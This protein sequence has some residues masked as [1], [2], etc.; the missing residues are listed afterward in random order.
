MNLE[1]GPVFNL[2]R[3]PHSFMFALISI[4]AIPLAFAACSKSQ[5]PKVAGPPPPVRM[6][7]REAHQ[8]MMK[9]LDI[10]SLRPGAVM[11]P[12]DSPNAANYNEAKAN[13]HPD[14][15]NPLVLNVGWKVNTPEMWWKVRRLEIVRDFNDDIY[16]RVPGDAPSVNWA[17]K[18][19]TKETEDGV[20]VVTKIV[21]GHVN[22][23]FYPPIKIDIPVTV[24]VPA[25]AKG[26]V[27]VILKLAFKPQVMSKA[28]GKVDMPGFQIPASGAGPSWKQQLLDKGWGYAIYYPTDLQPD[29]GADL[30][31][32]IIGLCNK[33]KPRSPDQWGAIRA[34][35]WGTSRVMDYLE[36]DSA[37][38]GKAVGI[39]GHSRFGK[40]AL[41]AMAYDQ[42]FAIAYISSSGMG[43][44]APYRRN[45]GERL[46]NLASV[47]EFYWM[48]G[49]FLKYAGPYH[50]NDLP[51]D[52]DD[53]IA[54]CAP[55]PVFIGVGSVAGDGWSD[56]E[57]EFMAEA[58]AG[59]AYEL[60]GKKGLGTSKLPPIGTA[61]MSG[62]LAFRQ[63][64]GGHTP[65]PDWPYFIKFASRYL[66]SAGR[67]H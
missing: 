1:E 23:S 58:A 8:R 59:P 48:D 7:A 10:K 35:A 32:G 36:T 4:V 3:N 50:S 14:L 56:P 47:H 31:E 11:S 60:L 46:E 44:A 15:P 66:K 49:D 9:V 29:N 52:A 30:T 16:G 12:A 2:R 64:H 55:R 27:P 28:A 33:G 38:D 19:V 61:L 25:K 54:L 26:P 5:K 20:P 65:A 13:P 39:M 24:T 67:E 43:G 53:L 6:T 41:A 57:G 34:W 21:V 42:R 63:H 22:N 17:V 62:D 45:F 18:K 40:A 37:V 51:V